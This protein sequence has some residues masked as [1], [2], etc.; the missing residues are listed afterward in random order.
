MNYPIWDTGVI[1]GGT[2]IAI[3]SVLHVYIAHLAVGG[4]LFIFL[5]D[6]KGFRDNNPKIHEY[7]KGHTWFFL[8][9]TMVFGGMSGVGIWFI[10]ALV[11]PSATSTL[12]HTFVFGWAIEWVFFLGEIVALLVYHYK[13]DKLER[14]ARLT[15]AFLYFLFAWLSLVV[16][17]GILS[18]MLTPGDWL[19][20]GNFWDGFLNPS[21]L[22]SMLFRSFA[23]FMIAGLFGYITSVFLKD[24]EF[25]QK[26][27]RY[28]TGWLLIPVV[29]IALTGL[30]YYYGIPESTRHVAFSVNRDISPFVGT[31]FISSI[32]LFVLGVFISLKLPSSLQKI[33]AFVLVLFG[34]GWMG[35][36]EYTREIVRKPYIIYDY[37]YA[38]SILK[39]QGDDLDNSGVLATAKWVDMKQVTQEN[40]SR[41]G[42]EIFNLECSSCHTVGGVRNDILKLTEDYPYLGMMCLIEGIGKVHSYMP[43]FY[44]T[45]SELEA[46]A[47]YIAGDLH[48]REIVTEPAG[49][50][51]EPETHTMPPFNKRRDDYVLLVWNDLG[52]HCI[53]DSDPFFVILP[54]ANTLEAQLIKRGAVPTIV[55]DGVKLE[56]EV[57]SGYENPADEVLFWDYA[58]I[59]FGADL[60]KNIGLKGAGL[61][62]E[63]HLNEGS[64]SFAVHAVPVVPYKANGKYNPYPLFTVKAI[65]EATGKIL[66][67]TK[68][69]APTST[70]MGCRNCHG[71][72]WR[73]NGVSGVGDE[74]AGNILKIHD[75]N[76]GTNLYQEALNGQPKLCQTCHADPAVGAAGRD[77]QRNLS[78]S[79]H[80]WHA[81]YMPFENEK[82]CVLCH[83]ASPEGNTQ[84]LRSI[85]AQLGFTCITCHGTIAD[86]A[87]SL[88]KNQ[89]DK[90][91]TDQLLKNLETVFAELQSEINPRTPWLN[92]PD[93]EFCH[94]GFEKPAAGVTSFNQWIPNFEDLY[95]NRTDNAGIKC[96]ACHGSPHAMYPARNDYGDNRDN[97][98]PMQYNGN[99]YPIGANKNCELCH[100]QKM[101][102]PIHHE[103][104]LRMFRNA[105]RIKV[106][107][108]K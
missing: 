23:A 29:G 50:K 61:K 62:G 71:G 81:N 13:F 107:N 25:R 94:I 24:S 38:N 8:L 89:L 49:Y 85:H 98:Q 47:Q 105:D 18:F 28:C 80:G 39:T 102:D 57:Q 79:I 21:F 69:V 92:E 91:G 65:D 55:T 58:K 82:P 7:V 22:S 88:L 103:N 5:T 31:F 53:S 87:V 97:I 70:E 16:I 76:H 41:A 95:R 106:A 72:D 32:V 54:P 73:W 104:M 99:S 59:I 56:Y 40:K 14:S 30:W 26:M 35:G 9:L 17:N 67:E 51:A 15:V 60:E 27:I 33:L 78:S 11:Q 36:F 44:G 96:A 48:S 63:L 19:V 75:R 46:L 43:R 84:C 66:A 1:G 74:T 45:R 68:V 20:T 34:L 90:N 12:I 108:S 77:E 52:M 93:C 2:L 42:K 37:M 86:H 83:P 6:W 101:E 64:N 4:G 100:K 10:I 3:I